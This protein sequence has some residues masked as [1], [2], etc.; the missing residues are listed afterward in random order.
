MPI[1]VSSAYQLFPFSHLMTHQDSGWCILAP[2]QQE[3]IIIIIIIIIN[4]IIIIIIIIII[5]NIIIII[6]QKLG[7]FKPTQQKIN[8]INAWQKKV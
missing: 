4:N 2:H 7:W 1:N 3:F 5:I 8:F 6:W